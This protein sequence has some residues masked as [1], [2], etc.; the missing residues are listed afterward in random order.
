MEQRVTERL[1]EL[2]PLV[3]EY[4]ELRAEAERFNLSLTRN[5][6]APAV[7]ERTRAK[8]S[9]RPRTPRKPSA[10]A[11]RAKAASPTPPA[12]TASPTGTSRQS[13]RREQVLELVKDNPGITVAEAGKRLGVDSTSLYRH[14]NRLTA[15]GQIRKAGRQLQPA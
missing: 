7:R 3:N 9:T 10:T 2:E 14:V 1:A 8:S 4:N 13:Q 12:P 5:G 15:D 6:N 11:K